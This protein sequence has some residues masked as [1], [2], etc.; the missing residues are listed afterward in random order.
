VSDW[1]LPGVEGAELTDDQLD[2]LHRHGTERDVAAGDV[3]FRPGDSAYDFIVV[4]SGA[5]DIEGGTPDDPVVVITH[6][7]RRFIG[8]FNM[9]T[10]QRV[11]LTAR[12]R[13]AGRILEVPRPE[14]RRVLATEGDLADVIVATFIARRRS[15]RESEGVGSLR[16]FG[17]RFSSGTMALRG[18]LVRS[19]VPHHWTD[20]DDEDD[21]AV[22][23]ARFGTRLGDAPVVVTPT[24]VLRRPTPGELAEH[25]GLTYHAVPGSSFDLVVVGAGPAGL[26]ASVYGASEGLDTVTLEAIA[27]GGQAGTSSR[28]ENYLGFPQGLSGLD[29]ADRATIQAQRLGARITNPCQG[30]H[31]DRGRLARRAAVRRQPGAGPGRHPRHRRRVPPPGRRGLGRPRDERDL[32]RRDRDRG[33]DVRGGARRR[34][35]RRELGRPGRAV[36]RREGL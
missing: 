34:D 18:F 16:L 24:A 36:P 2:V 21:P 5:V 3:L 32:L 28:I 11:F 29:L 1:T 19:G 33:P 26:A 8:E 35:R 20:L 25:L 22:L 6:G 31:E 27:V 23:L 12:V 13:E 17:S 4:L 7:P 14:L 30:R 15:L 9:I 10:E